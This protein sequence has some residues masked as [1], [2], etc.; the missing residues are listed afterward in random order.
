MLDARPEKFFRSDGSDPSNSM[1]TKGMNQTSDSENLF[2]YELDRP[3]EK[4]IEEAI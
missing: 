3:L 4:M 2:I 1:I